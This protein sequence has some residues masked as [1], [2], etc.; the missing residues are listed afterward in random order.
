MFFFLFFQ[1]W[2]QNRRAKSRRLKRKLSSAYQTDQSNQF[3]LPVNTSLS[4]GQKS[5]SRSSSDH[6]KQGER[7]PCPSVEDFLPH[8]RPM[9]KLSYHPSVKSNQFSGD[10]SFPLPMFHPDQFTIRPAEPTR[11]PNSRALHR[12]QPY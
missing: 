6:W 5:V 2:F 10:H 4:R 12:F 9:T 7:V 11:L 3:E 8:S 1:Y